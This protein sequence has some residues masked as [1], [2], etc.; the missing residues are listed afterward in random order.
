MIAWLERNFLKSPHW[1]NAEE[2]EQKSALD[3]LE[4][5]GH[6]RKQS[7]GR[8]AV[9]ASQNNDA[10]ENLFKAIMT[11]NKFHLHKGQIVVYL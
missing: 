5:S 6:K 3:L 11:Y 7:R 9:D 8:K 1:K 10:C 2:L 4:Q